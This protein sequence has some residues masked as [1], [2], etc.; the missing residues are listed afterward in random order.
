[1]PVE[2][3]KV[4]LPWD[5]LA[6]AHEAAADALRCDDPEAH[7]AALDELESARQ[8]CG[9]LGG[10]LVMMALRYGGLAVVRNLERLSSESFAA[11]WDRATAAAGGSK[12]AHDR[13]TALADRVR[14]LERRLD[15]L[16]PGVGEFGIQRG[17]L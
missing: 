7:R 5:R 14:A 9:S 13:I 17:R 6:D 15:D 16:T 11:A 8:E 4:R 1:M 10:L 3:V 12:A 2:D